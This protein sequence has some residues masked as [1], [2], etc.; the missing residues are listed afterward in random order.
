MRL[1][2][3]KHKLERMLECLEMIEGMRERICLKKS[4]L[5]SDSPV[6]YFRGLRMKIEGDLDSQERGLKRLESYYLKLKN[7]L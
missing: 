6:N 3:E 2:R 4:Q 5:K 7:S 1:I